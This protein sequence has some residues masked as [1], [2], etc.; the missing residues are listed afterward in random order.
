MSGGQRTTIGERR[1]MN[2]KRQTSRRERQTANVALQTARGERRPMG[3]ESSTAI[4]AQRAAKLRAAA[5]RRSARA[6]GGDNFCTKRDARR[7]RRRSRL[8]SRALC[9]RRS[10]PRTAPLKK[11]R[12]LRARALTPRDRSC[13]R[14]RR[15]GGACKKWIERCCPSPH[16]QSLSRTCAP[17]PSTFANAVTAATSVAT[18][19]TAAVTAAAIAAAAA[20]AVGGGCSFASRRA[21]ARARGGN[22]GGGDDD[23]GDT[24]E[25]RLKRATRRALDFAPHSV[26]SDLP[27][28]AQTRKR[29][30]NP[31]L[32]RFYWR[33]DARRSTPPP[34]SIGSARKWR[35]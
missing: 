32:T 22:D 6:R 23:G 34:H 31:K 26:G 7:R 5:S 30:Y 15:D 19:A 21:D 33:V 16:R 3:G 12:A 1:P 25:K 17:S 35:G 13:C 14:R 18:A 29:S 11:T 28:C 20:V 8:H 10:Y 4:C 9:R 27:L 2:D 24:K